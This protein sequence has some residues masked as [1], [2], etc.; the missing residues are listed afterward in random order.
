LEDDDEPFEEK[1]QR[2]VVT[3]EE[4][5]IESSRL[6]DEIRRNLRGLGFTS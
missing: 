1:I 3:L 6:E 4:Q 5:F 2:L